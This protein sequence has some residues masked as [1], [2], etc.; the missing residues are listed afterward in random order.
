MAKKVA[1]VSHSIE[2]ISKNILHN[3]DNFSAEVVFRVA[4]AKN[5][6]YTKSATLEDAIDMFKEVYAYEITDEITIADGSGVSRFNL[7]NAK[8]AC[9]CFKKLLLI[10][11]IKTLMPTANQGTLSNRMMFLENNLRA[12]TGTLA[13]M[14]SIM[15]TFSTR[16]NKDVV[17]CVIVQNSPERK[18]LLKN[19]E[20]SLVGILYKEL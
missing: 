4:G 9:E 14:S 15:G 10:S 18:A 8:F 7:I 3:S 16:E 12:K 19:F 1:V 17:F 13:N 20:N 5:I 11:D 2:E 6:D